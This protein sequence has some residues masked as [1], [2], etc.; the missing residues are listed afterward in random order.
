MPGRSGSSCGRTPDRKTRSSTFWRRRCDSAE[1][2]ASARGVF[3]DGD[4]GD[5][6]GVAGK[7]RGAFQER[8]ERPR[9]RRPGGEQKERAGGITSGSCS[10]FFALQGV[11]E[12]KV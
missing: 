11:E 1:P 8:S 7:L 5:G 3:R 4:V 10:G 9:R 2:L 12:P 6:R